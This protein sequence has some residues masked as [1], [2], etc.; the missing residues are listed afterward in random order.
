MAKKRSILAIGLASIALVLLLGVLLRNAVL[1]SILASQ[2]GKQ[3]G[4]HLDIHHLRW[5]L[6]S[7]RTEVGEIEVINPPRYKHRRALVIRN[8]KCEW[9]PSQLLK[10]KLHA[11]YL[12]LNAAEIDVVQGTDDHLNIETLQSF[13][14]SRLDSGE[15]RIDKLVLSA[16]TAR[17]VDDRSPKHEPILFEINAKETFEH[18]ETGKDYDTVSR[19]ILINHLP[20]NLGSILGTTIKNSLRDIKDVFR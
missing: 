5:P 12:E 13:T 7:A 17:Y 9:I 20:E 16:G 3:T 14:K 2:F 6:F 8:L 10:R 19:S 15:L 11:T 18:L 4:F 1:T